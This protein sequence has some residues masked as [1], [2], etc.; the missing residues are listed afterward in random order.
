[1]VAWIDSGLHSGRGRR[2]LTVLAVVL[3]IALLILLIGWGRVPPFAAFIAIALT[4]ALCFGMPLHD[5]G[6]SLERGVG[7]ML[8]GLTAI[9][10]FG[11]MFGRIIADSGAAR[12]IS[13]ALIGAGSIRYFIHG[14]VKLDRLRNVGTFCLFGVFLGPFVSSFLDSTFVTMNHWGE[15]LTGIFGGSD[16]PP[17]FSPR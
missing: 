16:L 15:G 2:V 7:D 17:T 3:L 10:C 11:A 5:I 8:G 12:S 4:G 14:P 9:I 6:K 1:M 13:K